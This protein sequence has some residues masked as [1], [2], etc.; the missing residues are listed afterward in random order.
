MDV[1][2][3]QPIIYGSVK[4]S[5]ES[6]QRFSWFWRSCAETKFFTDFTLKQW[7]YANERDD[8]KM[9]C[10][11]FINCEDFIPNFSTIWQKLSN[12]ESIINLINYA[13]ERRNLKT[14]CMLHNYPTACSMEL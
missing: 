4:K 3:L 9:R 2:Q 5:F 10:L 12:I 1:S 11:R 14:K 6:F 13:N 8:M 7:S